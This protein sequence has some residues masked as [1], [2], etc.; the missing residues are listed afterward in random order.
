MRGGRKG[1]DPNA[2]SATAA[3]AAAVTQERIYDAYIAGRR[4]AALAAA[5][6][7]GLFDRL[8]GGPK[9]VAALAAEL[10]LPER[11]VHLLCRALLA[12][13]LLE[14]SGDAVAL[15]ADAAHYLVRGRAHWLGGLIELEVEHFLSPALV[16]DALRRG[17][18]SVYGGDDPWR[19]HEADPARADAFLRAM[20]SISAEPARALAAALEP[21][22]IRRLLDVGGGSGVFA[23][24]LTRAHPELEVVVLELPATCERARAYLAAAP[25]VSPRIR[26]CAADFFHD[27]LPGGCDAALLS[28]ILHDY[29][30]ARCETL[31]RRLHG[32]LAPPARLIVHEK[33]IAE[34]GS[35]PLANALV[36][37]DMLVWT[38]GQQWSEPGLRALLERTGFGCGPAGPT[39]GLWSAIVAERGAPVAAEPTGR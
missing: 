31:L 13:G 30:P 6:R 8:D 1:A 14:R 4:S 3:G 19:A 18:P 32:A 24:E 38:E 35:G 36:D 16:L 26:L 22:S 37:L 29:P 34:D 15:A 17:G 10:R 27:P 7:I 9:P 39:S 20:H 11:G 12:M 21:G 5:V 23:I 2:A 33:L 25:D 28:Q